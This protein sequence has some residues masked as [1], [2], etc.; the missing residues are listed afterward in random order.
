M[1]LGSRNVSALFWPIRDHRRTILAMP[2]AERPRSR[3]APR[4]RL[5]AFA[6]AF[7]AA[8][9]GLAG[10]AHTEP[11]DRS[12]EKLK[13]ELTKMQADRD[14]MA[15]RLA[16]LELADERRASA[17]LAPALSGASAGDPVA[18]SLPVVRIG[19]GGERSADPVPGFGPASS[20]SSGTGADSDDVRPVL[21]ARGSSTG[22][23]RRRRGNERVASSTLLPEA[24]REYEA[25]LAL[26]RAKEYLKA[27]DALTTFLV[28]YPDHAYADNAMY[29][30]G[31][32]LYARGDYARAA[33][34][35]EGL[36]ARFPFGNKAPDALF[37][38][39]LCQ[40]QLGAHEQSDRTF[41]DLRDR[42][43]SSEAVRQMP[44]Q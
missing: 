21:E 33:Q 9:A 38:L 17:A 32:C 4:P 10:C 34:Q 37:K 36:V 27:L 8:F 5:R 35:F 39:G 31:E 11:A 18:P 16:A 29:W 19:K 22:S 24:K 15:E 1:G 30:R 13:V 23:A 25:A 28:R 26:L 42:Y 3:L 7:A 14:R 41:A 44:R 43:P 2:S 6:C 12:L 20:D 40:K